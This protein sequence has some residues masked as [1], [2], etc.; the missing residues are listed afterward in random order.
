M[1]RH[2][3]AHPDAI[4]VSAPMIELRILRKKRKQ[5]V[6]VE[7]GSFDGLVRITLLTLG[8]SL[9]H[10]HVHSEQK[11]LPAPVTTTAAIASSRSASS[12]ASFNSKAIVGVM[13][14]VVGAVEVTI[15]TLSCLS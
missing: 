9:Q 10:A 1:K 3:E 7:L 13:A 6:D 8:R 2:A 4:A 11:D 5:V 12:I 15:A 14:F